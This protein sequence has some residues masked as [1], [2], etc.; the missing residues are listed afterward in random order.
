MTT[1][2]QIQVAALMI[3]LPLIVGAVMQ[4]LGADSFVLEWEGTLSSPKS[5]R[6]EFHD[7]D[8]VLIAISL[9]GLVWLSY[10]VIRGFFS[11][12]SSKDQT[13]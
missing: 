7:F 10:L 13:A 12:K 5:A 6:F 8:A 1:K 4:V 11:S 9:I 2:R 3:V